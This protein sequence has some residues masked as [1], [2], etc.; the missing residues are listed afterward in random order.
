MK[1]SALILGCVPRIAVPIARSLHRQG[2]FVDVATFSEN[3]SSPR[4][5]AIREFVRVPNPDASPRDF[6]VAI[7]GLLTRGKHE[8]LIP[9]NDIALTAIL[10]HYER[11]SEIVKVACPNPIVVDRILDKN[12]TLDYAKRCG[13]KVPKTRVVAESWQLLEACEEVGFPVVLK[14]QKKTRSEL[15]KTLTIHSTADIAKRF[16][17]PVKFAEPMLAQEFCEGDG[18]GLEIVVSQGEAL[19]CFQHRRLKEL[20]PSGG[21]SV[22]ATFEPLDAE[23]VRDSIEL[24]RA[25]EWEGVAMV[26]FRVSPTRGAYLMEVNGRYWGT[27]GLPISAGIDFPLYQW[28]I[29]HGERPAVKPCVDMIRWRWTAGYV[30]R[31]HGLLGAA[32]KGGPY[33]S[34]L[35]REFRSIVGDFGG[36]TK[37]ALWTLADPAPAI[38]DVAGT[39]KDLIATDVK[40]AFRALARSRSA[41]PNDIRHGDAKG[42]AA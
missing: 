5:R 4:S 23:L 27:V 40:S 39:I 28:K 12:A 37:D 20:P 33:R 21:V 7:C 10:E 42:R 14:P 24:L 32:V 6:S 34:T 9:G 41:H 25:L 3:E 38:L 35:F 8:I 19:A 13:I 15:F 11:F 29:L 2:I 17:T 26:E 16:P 36:R 1:G 30:R 22:L 18:V 31:L